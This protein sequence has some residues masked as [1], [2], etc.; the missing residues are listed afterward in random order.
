MKILRLATASMTAVLALSLIGC[1]DPADTTTPAD[2][3]DAQFQK[4]VDC[5]QKNG[6]KASYTQDGQGKGHFDADA[7]PNDPKFKA[8]QQACAQYAPQE[9]KKTVSPSELDAL[10]KV[11]ACMRKQGISVVDPT[12]DDPALHVSG[13]EDE[14]KKAEGIKAT[15]EKEGQGASPSS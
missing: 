14:S 9:F 5:L 11:A 15:C 12:V 1:S 10:V 6:I 4:Y 3:E 7:G 13:S 2:K 8:A